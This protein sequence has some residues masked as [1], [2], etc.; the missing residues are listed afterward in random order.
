MVLDELSALLVRDH[1]VDVGQ[2]VTADALRPRTYT[3]PMGVAMSGIREDS[4]GARTASSP[5][6]SGSSGL[7]FRSVGS[8]GLFAWRTRPE[9]PKTKARKTSRTGVNRRCGRV[10]NR[11]ESVCAFEYDE[12]TCWEGQA[13]DARR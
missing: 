11:D 5:Q 9:L 3:A 4:M 7:S 2:T 12:Q 8:N 10:Y 1:C 13:A 6:A